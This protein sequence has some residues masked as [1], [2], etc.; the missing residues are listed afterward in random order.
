MML[1]A[2]Q[3]LMGIQNAGFNGLAKNAPY[4]DGTDRVVRIQGGDFTVG[5]F[6]SWSGCAWIAPANYNKR[7]ITNSLYSL[8][9]NSN[10][11]P[12]GG[13]DITKGGHQFIT[14]TVQHELCSL[15]Q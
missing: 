6:S 11:K 8:L 2:P 14:R 9:F 7:T 4:F 12:Y 1:A 3:R 15:G 5:Q 10:T 13:L